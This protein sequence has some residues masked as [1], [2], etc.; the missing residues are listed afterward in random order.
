MKIVAKEPFELNRI[1]KRL[2]RVLLDASAVGPG[3]RSV[4]SRPEM[5]VKASAS[6]D[7]IEKA[8]FLLQNDD[9]VRFERNR[10]IIVKKALA[11][12][13][14]EVTD[15]RAY[16]LLR[17]RGDDCQ[18]TVEIIRGMPG[19]V[20]ADSI[21]GPADVIFAVQGSTPENLAD[22]TIRVIARVE[23]MTDEVQLLPI[24]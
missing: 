21:D 7:M 11:R 5:A 10:M 8:L 9:A 15:S 24:R 17:T 6:L 1:K 20:M 23:E 12:I 16:V 2:A 3:A 14:A 22:L 13:T 19:V 4:L 18:E